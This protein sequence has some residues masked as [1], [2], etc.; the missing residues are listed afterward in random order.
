M[1]NL[2]FKNC[3]NN[4]NKNLRNLILS[5][6]IIISPALSAPQ[7]IHSLIEDSP[8]EVMDQVWQIIYR[9]YMDSTGKY[10]QKEWFKVRRKML[11]N[12][13]DNY[14][15]AY[16]S[17]RVMLSSL[18]DPY[19]RFL[20]PK[21][22][23]EMRIDTS[24]ELTGIGIQISIDEKNNDVLVISPIEGTP[25]FQ[26]GIK[27]KDKIISIDGT[28][29]KGMSIEN[30]VKL[31]RGKKGTEVKLG[32]SRDNQFFKLTLVRARIEIR[33]V[34]SRIN[35]SSSGNHFGY[36]RLKQF[37]ANA[38]K[39]MR[40]ALISLERNDPD[41]YI[42]DVR[43]NPGGLLE[44][45]ID[46]SRQLL[47]KG[48][49][50]ST[51][52]KDGITDVRRARGN[53]LTHKPIAILV[54]EGSASASEILSGA[55]Q[56]NK[57]GILIG[58]KTFGKGLVQSVRPLVDGS[59]LTVTVAKYLTPRGTDIHKYGIVPDIEVELKSI[60]GNRFSSIDLGTEKD[61]QYSVAES[62]LIRLLKKFQ[63]K[64]AYLP[65]SSNFE[66]AI[67]SK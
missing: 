27:A 28:L 33:T 9:D 4:S 48:V 37:S 19:T 61:S 18:E 45:S 47:D 53:A 62:A 57:R 26:A 55:I 32:I 56:D 63:D 40:K 59:G 49:I 11:S 44:A 6:F 54:N 67:S 39:E 15:Q 43:G 41:A 51:K 1:F 12:K 8:K 60:K 3:P 14:S 13:Y 46:I 38:A 22:F 50:V 20:E 64:K 52:T 25:A 31:I 65:N 36:I 66:V 58:K 2:T 35:K 10:D 30:V 23:N 29:T 5:F 24:G 21:E 7:K 17:I 16:E 34:V 42:I